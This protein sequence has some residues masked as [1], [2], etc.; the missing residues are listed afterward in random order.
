MKSTNIS[1][2]TGLRPVMAAPAAA[3]MIADSVIGVSI[4]RA[5][6]YLPIRPLVTPMTPP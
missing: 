2:A 4:T 1:S 6:P 5:S 3:P